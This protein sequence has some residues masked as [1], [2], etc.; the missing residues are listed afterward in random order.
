MNRPRKLRTTVCVIFVLA[1]AV[2]CEP[3]YVKKTERFATRVKS[4]VNPDELQ[5]WATNLIAGT[6]IADRRTPVDIK[7]ADVPKFVR[8]IYEDSPPDVEVVGGDS[9]SYVE[10]WFGSGFGHWGL[11]VGNPSLVLQTSETHYI[12]KWKPGIYFWSGP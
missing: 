5:A 1:V 8:A 7:D 4:V 6:T 3:G 12:V 10:I 11:Y 9:D 2:G